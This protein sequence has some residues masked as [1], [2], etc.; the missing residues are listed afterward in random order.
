V[1]PLLVAL[2]GLP[3]SGK[4]TL[5]AALAPR[6]Q[7]AVCRVDAVEAAMWHAGVAR[8]QPTGLAAYAVA[9][10]VA[11]ATLAVGTPVVVDA[12]NPVAEA[13]DGW[14]ALAGEVGARLVPVE[15]VCRDRFEH[16][17]R[18]AERVSDIPGFVVP[19]WEQ[20]QALDYEPWLGDRVL[21]DALQ[22]LG[23]QVDLVLRAADAP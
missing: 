10:A 7:A 23:E 6:L 15:V 5:A 8:D 22:P 13:R 2:G 16:R 20:V 9:H 21:V 14:V 4:T 3:G 12:V 1:T 11:R 17:R 19:T 18:V